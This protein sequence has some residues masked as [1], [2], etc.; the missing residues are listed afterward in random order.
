MPSTVLFSNASFDEPAQATVLRS[1]ESIKRKSLED[2]TLNLYKNY[3]NKSV[4]K[5]EKKE[6]L[7]SG[8]S[9]L[10]S[11][12]NYIEKK[13]VNTIVESQSTKINFSSDFN[14]PSVKKRKLKIIPNK[15]DVAK[16]VDAKNKTVDLMT[17]VSMHFASIIFNFLNEFIMLIICSIKINGFFNSMV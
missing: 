12:D 1:I 6:T 15:I 9:I 3:C 7:I 17:K 11:V 13:T 10:E 5:I 8:K 14:S 4:D 2:D 16:T